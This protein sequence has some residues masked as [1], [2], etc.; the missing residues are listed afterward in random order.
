MIHR[1]ERM[2]LSRIAVTVAC[3]AAS[4]LTWQAMGGAAPAAAAFVPRYA[5]LKSDRV[6]LRSGPGTDYPTVWVYRRA[7]LPLEVIQEYEGWRQVRDADGASG[8]VLQSFLSGRRT[9]L[10]EPWENKPG[11]P[12]RQTPLFNDTSERASQVA[13]VEAGVIANVQSCDGKWCWVSVEQYKGY[14]PQKK[15]W[16]VYEAEVVK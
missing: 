5:S 14:V 15:L 8:W 13:Q 6:N 9:A 3:A 11:A 2:Q 1:L 10:V 12:P 4:G 7:G 16:G